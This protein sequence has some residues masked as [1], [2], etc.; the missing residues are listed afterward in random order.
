MEKKME[1]AK[2]TPREFLTGIK[3]ISKYDHKR[4][5]FWQKEAKS[6]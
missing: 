3:L 5:E 2:D 6:V 4:A 1:E